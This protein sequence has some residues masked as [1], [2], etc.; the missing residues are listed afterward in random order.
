MFFNKFLPYLLFPLTWVLVLLALTGIAVWFDRRKRALW[1]VTTATLL[2]WLL[3]APRVA[4]W[5]L[6]SL[7][8][9]YPPVAAA[10]LPAAGAIVLLGGGVE[11]PLAPRIVAEMNEGGDRLTRAAELYHAGKAPWILVSG[12]QVFPDPN[13]RSE[14]EYH[15]DFLRRL[16]VPEEAIVLE[17]SSRNTADNARFSHAILAQREV[18]HILLV[19]SAFHMPRSML[20]FGK[21]GLRV[22]PATTDVL[23]PLPERPE[24]LY[25]LPDAGALAVTQLA[26]REHLGYWV[27][28]VKFL[29]NGAGTAAGES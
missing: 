12:G 20:L 23:S 26:L 28:R 6:L 24:I 2:L 11:A 19:T 14:A 25:W 22:T 4:H 21:P 17:T 3:S 16:G 7:E 13:L 10:E 18:S 9:Q 15:V 1:L 5:L 27:Y 8:N 29:L